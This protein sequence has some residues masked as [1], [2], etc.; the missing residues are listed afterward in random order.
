M[1]SRQAP[2][3]RREYFRHQDFVEWQSGSHVDMCDSCAIER[4]SLIPSVWKLIFE[5]VTSAELMS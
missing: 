4:M 2:S 1:V 5:K 3:R